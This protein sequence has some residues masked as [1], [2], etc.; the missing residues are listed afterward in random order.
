MY[1]VFIM[2][3]Y[4]YSVFI[5]Y[6]GRFVPGAHCGGAVGAL[7]FFCSGVGVGAACCDGGSGGGPPRTSSLAEDFFFDLGLCNEG[8]CTNIYAPADLNFREKY[9]KFS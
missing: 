6:L 3:L 5:R 4:F 2:F 9:A 7:D 1:S 8:N